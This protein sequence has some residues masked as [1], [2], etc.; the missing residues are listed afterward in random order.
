MKRLAL[1]FTVTAVVLLHTPVAEAGRIYGVLREATPTG[2]R[3][4]GNVTVQV[5]S[6]TT[7]GSTVTATVLDETKTRSDGTFKLYVRAKGSFT[8]RVLRHRD[9]HAHPK[10]E[11]PG[12]S[13]ISKKEPVRQNVDLY[14]VKGRWVLRSR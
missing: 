1:G 5:V 7:S 13:V 4:V 11:Y 12:I 9:A 8:M 14:V 10:K 3:A 6:W 2:M